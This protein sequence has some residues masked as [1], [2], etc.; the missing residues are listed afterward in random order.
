[1]EIIANM[2]DAVSAL[3]SRAKTM[4]S[5]HKAATASGKTKEEESDKEK[6]KTGVSTAATDGKKEKDKQ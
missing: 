6:I 1:M 4:S 5:T 2:G 3:S